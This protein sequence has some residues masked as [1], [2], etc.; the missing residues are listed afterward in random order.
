[1]A[2]KL[3]TLKDLGVTISLPNQ[4]NTITNAVGT[5][6]LKKEAIKRIN[7][8]YDGCSKDFRCKA[9]KRDMWFYAIIEGDLK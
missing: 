3:K 4:Y 1:M 8:C 6:I 5:D 7:S 9:C 2:K